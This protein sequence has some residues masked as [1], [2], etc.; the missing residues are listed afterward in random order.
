M[1]DAIPSSTKVQVEMVLVDEG[2]PH[3]WGGEAE[4]ALFPFYHVL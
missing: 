4:A 1:R 2:W 3:E